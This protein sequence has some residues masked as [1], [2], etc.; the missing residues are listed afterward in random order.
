MTTD[1]AEQHEDTVVKIYC[2][3]HL[4]L[5]QPSVREVQSP[6]ALLLI[7]SATN[8][9]TVLSCELHFLL[10]YSVFIVFSWPL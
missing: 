8:L 6:G 2:V 7:S 4:L 5:S 10:L 9:Q 3:K 1:P